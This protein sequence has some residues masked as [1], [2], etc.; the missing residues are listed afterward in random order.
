MLG[1]YY[2][3]PG[4]KFYDVLFKAG[5]TYKNFCP[6]IVTPSISIKWD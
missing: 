3:G 1:F 2:T 4:N 6:M 5:F